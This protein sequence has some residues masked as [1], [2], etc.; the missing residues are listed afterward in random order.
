MSLY[1]FICKYFKSPIVHPVIHV[2]DAYKDMEAMLHKNGLMKCSILPSGHLY[3]PVRPFRCNN[4]LSF[5]L[6][7]TCA[8]QQIRTTACTH[9]TVAERA[10]IGKWVLDEIR[11]AVQK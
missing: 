6:R 4:I 11:L 7:R 3:N 10:L 2:G 8:I 9:E 1:P 5:C